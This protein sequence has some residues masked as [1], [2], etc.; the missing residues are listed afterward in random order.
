MTPKMQKKK[1]PEIKNDNT[2]FRF[3]T[4]FQNGSSSVN[5][6]VQFVIKDDTIDS[7]ESSYL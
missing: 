4:L 6:F 7:I 1:R 2:L 3:L 5:G